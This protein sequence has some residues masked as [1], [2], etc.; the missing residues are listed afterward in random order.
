MNGVHAQSYYKGPGDWALHYC[1][2]CYSL[3]CL[4]MTCIPDHMVALGSVNQ[5]LTFILKLKNNHGNGM[6]MLTN[7]W[8]QCKLK[9]GLQRCV[10]QEEWVT[11]CLHVDLIIFTSLNV[12]ILFSAFA[13]KESRDW[14]YRCYIPETRN[15]FFNADSH[16]WWLCNT[17]AIHKKHL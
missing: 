10:M 9:T 3:G 7:P 11:K 15:T 5:P 8:D 14:S 4:I 17:K 12:N 1:R 2:G 6:H 16:M 13:Y